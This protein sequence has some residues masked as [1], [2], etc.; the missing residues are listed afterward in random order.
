M[1]VDF[2]QDPDF[3]DFEGEEDMDVFGEED[4]EMINNPDFEDYEDMLEEENFEEIPQRRK[5][6]VMVEFTSE[7]L[8]KVRKR[9]K[10]KNAGFG[11]F[12][13]CVQILNDC[14]GESENVLKQRMKTYVIT[15]L[16]L[17]NSYVKF[18]L[19]EFPEFLKEKFGLR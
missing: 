7:D 6:P 12:K 1:Q 3:Q 4:E 8:E 14:I 13:K 5:Q 10:E 9:L 18:M 15:D 16:D 2:D 11:T 17:M 19:E